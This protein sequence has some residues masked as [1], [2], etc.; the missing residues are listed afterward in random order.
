MVDISGGESKEIKDLKININITKGFL[1]F[2]KK[3]DSLPNMDK[4]PYAETRSFYQAVSKDRDLN[5]LEKLLEDFFGP[6]IKPAGKPIP[7]LLRNNP[8]VKYLNGLREEQTLFIRK[9]KQGLYYGALWPWQRKEKN[10]VFAKSVRDAR[11]P[12]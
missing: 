2:V 11:L 1:N 3:I 8:S 4:T 6:P 12:F 7:M 10:S 5:T 9:V